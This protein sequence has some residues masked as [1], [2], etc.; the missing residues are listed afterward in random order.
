MAQNL[1]LDEIGLTLS[2]QS[3]GIGEELLCM[4]Q[5]SSFPNGYKRHRLQETHQLFMRY[6]SE[7]LPM[8]ADREEYLQNHVTHQV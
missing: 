1:E 6:E 2:Y 3:E 4:L 8:L 7:L 5:S